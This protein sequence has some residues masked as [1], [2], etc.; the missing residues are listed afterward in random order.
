MV[1]Q[2]GPMMNKL[3]MV[4]AVVVV[5]IG[6]GTTDEVSDASELSLAETVVEVGG[7]TATPDVAVTDELKAPGEIIELSD[8]QPPLDV[9]AD[10]STDGFGP[11]PGDAG[12][13]CATGSDCNE[14]LCIQT[15]NGMQ[16]TITCV[17]ECP[18][19]W[20]CHLHTPSL[21]DEIYVCTPTFLSLCRP[22]MNTNECMTNGVD[23]GEACVA[24]G[25][26]GNFCGGAC[27]EDAGCPA[28][29]H[30]QDVV[31][32]AGGE[33]RQ[34]VS[35]E[36]CECTQTF[37]D[38]GAATDC[39]HENDWGI[40][41]GQS[42]CLAGGLTQCSAQVPA[43][44]I[45]DG[46][47][48]D[49]DQQVDEEQGQA[50]CT[51]INSF[52]TCPGLLDCVNGAP[53]CQG[54]PAKAEVCDGEDN[55]CDGIVDEG[56]EDTDGDGVADC[57]V[58]DKDGDGVVDGLDNCP[59]TFNPGQADFDL[60]T[61]G[62]TCDPDDDNDLTADDDDCAPKDPDM[63][64]GAEEECDGKDNDC[65]FVVDEGF[66]D[67]D[68]DG[69]KDCLDDD[70][71]NDGSPDGLDCAP[72]DPAVFPDSLE[73]CD[74]LDNDCDS[75][76][77][78][79]LGSIQCGKG[80]CA[81][82]VELCMAGKVQLCDPL[83]GSQLEVCDGVDNDCDGLIDEDLGTATC[84]IGPCF[85]TVANCAAGLSQECDP[86]AGA[87]DEVC[88]GIDNDC[89]GKI[90]ED[91]GV[92]ACGVGICFHSVQTCL[93]GQP[94]QCDPMAGAKPETCD[95]VD[96]DCDGKEDEGFGVVTCGKGPCLHS[97]DYCIDGKITVCDPYEGAQIETCDG[98]DN[99]CNGIVDDGLGSTT[100]GLGPCFHT[101]AN[102][103]D[104]QPQQCDP[105]AGADDET[106]DG[107][108]NDCDGKIDEEMPLLACGQGSCFH[109][110][111][112]CV[113]GVAY[114]C[115]PFEG[116]L[117]ESCDGIDNDCDGEVDEELGTVSC[118]QGACFHVQPYCQ[119]GKFTVCDPFAGVMPEQ[120]DGLDN[121]CDGLADEETG[122]MSCGKGAC[123]HWV[124]AC[125]DGQPQ[126]CDPFE[127]KE[128][129][130]C[131]GVDNDCDGVVDP[132]DSTN[133]TQFYI[134]A[135]SDGFGVDGSSQC[136]CDLDP[137][138]ST[139]VGGDCDDNN[140][141][142]NPGAK[143]DCYTV[144]DED[145][146]DAVNNGCLY[147]TC[148][149]LLQ[150]D[151]GAQ[152]GNFQ[153]DTDGDG[154]KLPFVVECDMDTDGG[155]WTVFH[156]SSDAQEVKVQGCEEPGCLKITPAYANSMAEMTDVVALSSVA[157]QYLLYKCIDSL[158]W[159]GPTNYHWW[160]NKSGAKMGYWPGGTANCDIND[161]VWRQD[162]GWVTEKDA[163][164]VSSLQFGDVSPPNEE[165]KL[166]VG[167]LLCR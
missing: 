77:D 133:C 145:C 29:Y 49:C 16:C 73:K 89:D 55:D 87:L 84:G 92:L 131:D 3:G 56:F 20:T 152:T 38:S 67:S 103:L 117:P 94:Q 159:S 106:C 107:I 93:A 144:A 58:N 85:H 46:L 17:E 76:V 99:D 126:D 63:H 114:E 52:G 19:D 165:G 151:P 44:E 18:F 32:V 88:D 48:N 34:C 30:C 8:E 59:S 124:E 96:N 134:D 82:E 41:L 95:G 65:N 148:Y 45:C 10:E 108:D 104:G 26:A 12:Y 161:N 154:P 2:W 4:L 79:E 118:G 50:E 128:E 166:T 78:E 68:F 36:T 162:G 80:A 28:G 130:A 122:L 109:S 53:V 120:C 71:D 11:E 132:A 22:C 14:G 164:P 163:L 112:S 155:G 74:G 5:L 13:P 137:P 160:N 102:C 111:Q 31:D 158:F 141:L 21:P 157:K 167:P 100:C 39:Y 135:D 98:I 129:E 40:C 60:D 105:L 35:L 33:D 42:K 23:A 101:A 51:V 86:L 143:E 119:D 9:P 64:P 138:Y 153:I 115:N 43:E 150:N 83:A 140:I 24:Y 75:Q 61:V 62:D 72:T 121:D 37:V 156:H 127:G 97:H 91:M 15:Q 125:K 69:I 139:A 146:D 66:P 149:L 7:E 142:V 110:V 57:L 136:L 1:L 116:A 147:P 54:E 113:G 123:F 81:H 25:P 27:A 70:D 47:D 6:C 90:D